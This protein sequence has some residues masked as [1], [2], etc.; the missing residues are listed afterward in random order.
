M[1]TATI[2][3]KKIAV[4]VEAEDGTFHINPVVTALGALEAAREALEQCVEFNGLVGEV[5]QIQQ[6]IVN[7]AE[8]S[9]E[10]AS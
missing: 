10:I 5:A 9:G 4:F 6:F 7:A 8:R 1:A 3:K 2:T